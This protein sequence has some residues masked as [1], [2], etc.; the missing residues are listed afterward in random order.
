M[1]NGWLT[2]MEERYYK[3]VVVSETVT[4]YGGYFR[5]IAQAFVDFQD[6]D[7][8]VETIHI[9]FGDSRIVSIEESTN[10]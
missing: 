4:T 8:D 10:D 3:I 1:K 7:L 9:G 6:D 5:N 2:D